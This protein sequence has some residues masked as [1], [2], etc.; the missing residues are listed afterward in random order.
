M[1]KRPVDEQYDESL[2]GEFSDYGRSSRFAP[3]WYILPIAAL[4]C[5]GWYF[6][7]KALL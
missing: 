4:S 2:H 5:V 7:V 3:G 1:T 6:I